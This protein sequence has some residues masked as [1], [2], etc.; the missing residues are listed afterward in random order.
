MTGSAAQ[1]SSIVNRQSEIPEAFLPAGLAASIKGVHVRTIRRRCADGA[2]AAV[3]V[4]GLW[5]VDPAADPALRLAVGETAPAPAAAGDDLA[6]LSQ[7]QRR[8]AFARMTMVRQYL[9]AL[10]HKPA[11]M[12]SRDFALEFARQWSA[13][14]GGHKT[15]RTAL[16][17]WARAWKAKGIAG[18]V[19]RRGGARTP[20]A[21]SPE[22][23]SFLLGLYAD[24]AGLSIPYIYTIVRGEA[25]ERGW[26]VPALRT[27][28]RWVRRHVDPKLLAAGRDPKKF[29]DRMVPD[30]KRD[31]TVVPAMN[32][33]VADHR[34]ADVWLARP[35]AKTGK[36]A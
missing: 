31:W 9:A 18:L 7:S 15:S 19:D 30:L 26:N 10:E 13:R 29:R 33:W 2:M 16:L 14:N 8:R 20:A 34:Q 35:D 27:V 36:T 17:R 24:Q 4:D 32:A 25:E 1:K 22:A 5:Y 23:K 12:A 11:S 6:G 28:Q 3:Q 21:F